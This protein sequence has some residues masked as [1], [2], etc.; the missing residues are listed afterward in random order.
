MPI[1]GLVLDPLQQPY[2][3]FEPFFTHILAH[4]L[5]HGL[6]PHS[7]TVGGKKTTVRLAMKD[8]SSALEEAK[9]DVA[10]L[11]ALQYLV[12]KGVLPPETEFRMHVTFLASIFRSVRFGINEAHGKG[13]ALIFNSFMTEG[14]YE[15]ND[16]TGTFRVNFD[17]I[18]PAVRNLTGEIMTLQA[19]GDYGGAR[20]LLNTR[21]VIDPRMQRT[22]A[23]LSAI[24]VDIE[25]V[26][27]GAAR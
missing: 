5:M 4:E 8:I 19:R 11:F 14:A 15:Y 22:L 7:I 24:P 6:G 1:S 23:K 12:E 16:T 25:P 2:V 18:R 20:N 27:P 17:R 13:V 21:A 3:A 10:G 9:A 26:A